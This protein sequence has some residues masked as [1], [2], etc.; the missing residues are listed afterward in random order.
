MA[1]TRLEP[2]YTDSHFTML[3]TLSS[4]HLLNCYDKKKKRKI[5]S[6][7]KGLIGELSLS[8]LWRFYFIPFVS[9]SLINS[10]LTIMIRIKPTTSIGW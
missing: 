9:V 6:K 7:L 10:D 5:A 4:C 3:F 2:W 1:K 8:V